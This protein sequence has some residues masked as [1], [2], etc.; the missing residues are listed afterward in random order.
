MP[1]D[2][3]AAGLVSL[4]W[5]ACIYWNL[6]WCLERMGAAGQAGEAEAPGEAAG[7]AAPAASRPP[8]DAR[9]LPPALAGRVEAILSRD[10]AQSI[11]LFLRDRL[12]SYE[13]VVAAFDAGDRDALRWL[14]S[15]EVLETFG[16][17]IDLREIRGQRIETAFAWI[18]PSDIVEA[19]IDATRMEI[20]IRFAGAYFEFSRDSIGLLA[21]GA[22]AMRRCRDVWTFAQ[23]LAPGGGGWRVV[24]TEADA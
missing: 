1:Q 12:A 10:G 14:V 3:D 22:P 24:A 18:E 9:A 20:A 19:R 23:T 2:A 15:P 13:A 17:A 21:K 11:E 16:T 7:I 8:M 4:I 5:L 6:Y